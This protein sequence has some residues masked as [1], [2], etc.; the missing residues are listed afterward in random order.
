MKRL[1]F[2]FILLLNILTN[3]SCTKE[4]NPVG[5]IS[6][7]KPTAE[8][9]FPLNNSNLSD[10]TIIEV[11][12]SDDKGIARVEIY[13]DDIIVEKLYLA[14]YRYNWV[15]TGIKDSSSHTIYAK[16]F[17]TDNN[18]V[19]TKLI[20][21]SNLFL[22]PSNLSYSFYDDKKIKLN[23]Q[24]NSN[25]ETGFEIELSTDSILYSKVASVSPNVTSVDILWQFKLDSTYY[26]RVKS[27][28]FNGCKVYS[29]LIA[30]KCVF[31]APSNL[32]YSII[33]DSKINLK[34]QDNSSVET[35]FEVEQSLDGIVFAKVA[36]VGVS[37]S[38]FE[39]ASNFL[40][41]TKY[42]YRLRAKCN[43]NYSQYSN[44]ASVLLHLDAPTSLYLSLLDNSKISLQ[45]KDN[46]NCEIG[47]QIEQSS[48]NVNFT[49]VAEVG[50]NITDVS[51]TGDYISQAYYF[52]SRA[53]SKNNTGQYSKAAISGIMT[54]SDVILYESADKTVNHSPGLILSSGLVVGFSD[55]NKSAMDLYYHS[56]DYDLYST[57]IAADP[58]L[59]RKTYFIKGNGT[60]INDRINAPKYD[61]L[62]WSNWM[63]DTSSAYHF[64][65]DNDRHYSKLI[66]TERGGGTA[67]IKAWIKVKWIYNN[68]ANCQ[69]F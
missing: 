61:A 66:I 14:P 9:I 69:L 59:L 12:A 7:D 30:P 46:S 44:I 64:I 25:S 31:N 56:V 16:A 40:L 15:T 17:D 58:A 47:Y 67:N 4:S 45:W 28:N 36:D 65:Y 55:V 10:T 62:E 29:N 6:L 1:F 8:I 13:I 35:G 23:W 20:T 21:V 38:T 60:D 39:L 37:D 54:Y 5:N 27:N 3:I 24:D 34:W 57:A 53:I 11:K 68:V 48:D 18:M 50:P 63:P 42:Y 43:N 22:A 33:D 26:F 32:Y 19:G 41:N 51:L 52:R 2:L 49:K